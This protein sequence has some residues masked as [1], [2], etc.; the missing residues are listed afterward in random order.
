LQAKL[1]KLRGAAMGRLE[2]AFASAGMP[3]RRA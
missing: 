2:A 1:E 3:F